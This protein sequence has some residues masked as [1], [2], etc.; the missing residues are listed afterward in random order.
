MKGQ[1]VWELFVTFYMCC[2]EQALKIEITPSS[3]AHFLKKFGGQLKLV[4]SKKALMMNGIT[5]TPGQYR[6]RMG[7]SLRAGCCRL[8]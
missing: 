8:G 6:T 5:S 3:S 2:A 4:L 1:L 7:K